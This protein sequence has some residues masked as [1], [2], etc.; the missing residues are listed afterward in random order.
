[1]SYG[2]YWWISGRHHEFT[3]DAYVSGNMIRVT[4]RIAGTVVALYAEDTDLVQ[5]R[6]A[7]G[8]TG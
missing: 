1:M 2:V 4:P 5:L 6:T 7:S 3:D 8:A